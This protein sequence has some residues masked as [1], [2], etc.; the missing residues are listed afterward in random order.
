[1][2]MQQMEP[3]TESAPVHPPLDGMK[4]LM[5]VLAFVGVTAFV[6]TLC[7]QW[8][9]EKE[10]AAV[11]ALGDDWDYYEAV[12]SYVIIH[13]GSDFIPDKRPAGWKKGDRIPYQ[14]RQFMPR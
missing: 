7:Y 14:Q 2:K 11:A 5:V 8:S 3:T 12:R 13:G 9:K 6:G 10:T 1:M 4:F